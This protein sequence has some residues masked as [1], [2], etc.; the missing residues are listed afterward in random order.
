MGALTINPVRLS[1]PMG[2]ML[3]FLG[4]KHC[5]PLIH[6]A[7]GCASFSKVFFTRHFH[8]PIPV[9]TTAVSDIT[10]VLDGGDKIIAEAI[11]N[12]LKKITP[13]LVGLISTGLTETKG[14]DLRGIAE[15]LSQKTVW[16]STPDYAGGL[17]SGWAAAVKAI[18]EQVVK[19]AATVTQ[20]I[21]LLPNVS[22]TPIEVE[23]LKAL[24]GSFGFEAVALPDLSESMDGHLGEKQATMTQGGVSIGA[25][26]QLAQ[27]RAA[28]AIGASMS[29]PL[30]ALK[31]KNPALQGFVFEH[32][33]GLIAGDTLIETLMTLA[34]K[35]DVPA[36]V[37]RWRSRLQDMLLDSHFVLGKTRVLLAIEPDQ[38]AALAAILAEAGA[39]CQTASDLFWAEQNA[40][41]WDLLIS[42][43][44]GAALCKRLKKAHL[45]IGFPQW[46]KLG[47]QLESFGGYE[48]SAR[49]LALAA[50]ALGH[51]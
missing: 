18:I 9:Q 22:Q 45:E 37:K 25:I 21:A 44:H 8:D 32:I 40:D 51:H 39:K 2:A 15:R 30:E 34:G 19:P 10:A 17:E 4:V 47:G 42:G 1:A 26:E 12:I 28:F 20:K 43:T 48:G 35:T 31:K 6:G 13:D 38:A 24:I 23:N 11:D 29:A 16:V 46:E 14:D 27:C 5:M 33:G 7:Q 49:F 36:S 50:N 41:G 3:V